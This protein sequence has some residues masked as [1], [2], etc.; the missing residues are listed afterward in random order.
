[1]NRISEATQEFLM[2]RA[3]QW[4]SDKELCTRCSGFVWLFRCASK[5]SLL[6]SATQ[7]HPIAKQ[8]FLGFKCGFSGTK[9][10]GRKPR[11]FN[12][13]AFGE[14]SKNFCFEL[15]GQAILDK[16]AQDVPF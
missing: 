12:G 2:T 1:M 10:N 15:F 11:K 14:L 16:G 5:K 9:L 3:S 4:I 7:V 13:C 8:G 6:D